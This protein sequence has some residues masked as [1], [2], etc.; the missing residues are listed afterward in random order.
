LPEEDRG[1]VSQAVGCELR[2]LWRDAEVCELNATYDYNANL[3]PRATQST[4]DCTGASGAE[5]MS[6]RLH[7]LALEIDG[8]ERLRVIHRAS[9]AEIVPLDL[10]MMAV[11][12]APLTH[13]ILSSVSNSCMIANK[14]FHPF[15]WSFNEREKGVYRFPRLV[16]GRCIARRAG[17]C[18]HRENLPHRRKG[19]TDFSYFLRI[20]RWQRDLGLP[21]EVFVSGGTYFE[22][23]EEKNFDRQ[24]WN[25]RKPQYIHFRNHFLV[26][27][28]EK[29]ISEVR[30]WLYIEEMLP[31]QTSWAHWRLH[32]PVEAVIDCYVAQ[33]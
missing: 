8:K 10:G 15:S 11:S 20:R 31:D 22:W 16:F 12:F 32:R 29:I 9:G 7:D 25:R 19:D 33:G 30:A 28:L 6:I 13:H 5:S 4:V 26:S 3:H 17:W 21:E 14:P 23:M 18:V 1:D 24:S 27:I 2:Q